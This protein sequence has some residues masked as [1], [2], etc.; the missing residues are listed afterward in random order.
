[1]WIPK[2]STQNTPYQGTVSESNMVVWARYSL[3]KT[4]DYLAPLVSFGE[5]MR[6]S[7]TIAL[8]QEDKDFI[9]SYESLDDF[10]GDIALVFPDDGEKDPLKERAIEI[11]DQQ[12][13]L[14]KTMVSP[15]FPML[16]RFDGPEYIPTDHIEIACY[17]RDNDFSEQMNQFETWYDELKKKI[18]REPPQVLNPNYPPL[19]NESTPEEYAIVAMVALRQTIDRLSP[20]ILLGEKL[21]QNDTIELFDED[22][23]L[24]DSYG[25]LES[26]Y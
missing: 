12:H 20:I 22:K 7:G 24:I 21:R 11:M 17:L 6:K 4:L 23:R 9:D 18:D 10:W 26:L 13:E 5:N 25:G 16:Y 8:S 3:R 2:K 19:T 1:M 15:I 14:A